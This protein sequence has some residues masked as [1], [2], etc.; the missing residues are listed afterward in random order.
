[1][2]VNMRRAL[3][4]DPA[5]KS[6]NSE[7]PHSLL[8]PRITCTN[9]ASECED[10]ELIDALVDSGEKSAFLSTVN[11]ALATFSPLVLKVNRHFTITRSSQ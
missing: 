9:H 2:N 8:T 3:V 6:S 11:L 5:L 1:M 7:Q 10:A 4:R